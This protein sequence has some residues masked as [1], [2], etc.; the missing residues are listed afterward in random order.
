MR[1]IF[2]VLLVA[3]L[4]FLT[5]ASRRVPALSVGCSVD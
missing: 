4:L 5:G 1:R 2:V 3:S